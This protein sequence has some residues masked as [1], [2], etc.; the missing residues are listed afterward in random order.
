LAFASAV[1][2]GP[3]G[4]ILGAERERRSGSTLGTSFDPRE[5]FDPFDFQGVTEGL[6]D[7]ERFDDREPGRR[8]VS[9][10]AV[11]CE[12]AAGERFLLEMSMLGRLEDERFRPGVTTLGVRELERPAPDERELGRVNVGDFTLDEFVLR[13]VKLGEC[14][15]DEPVLRRLNEGEPEC[16][17]R[18]L[19]RV[20]VRPL[21]RGTLGA[22][23][24]D[25]EEDVER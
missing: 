24:V 10:G 11:R 14:E 18:V 9:G 17:P 12:C 3:R 15:R 1:D 2:R 5:P 16:D 13:R 20:Y 7:F 21:D 25:R 19:D 23:T 4:S 22:R 8:M 6:S